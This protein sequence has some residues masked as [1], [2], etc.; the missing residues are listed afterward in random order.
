MWGLLTEGATAYIKSNTIG[1]HHQGLYNPGL[2]EAL[3]KARQAQGNDLPPTLKLILLVSSY[4]QEQYHGR[5]YAKAQNLR[6]SLRASYD[7]T[8][9]D[10][11]VP[12]MPTTPMKSHRHVPGR[13]TRDTISHGWNMLANTGPFDMTGHPGLSIPCSKS[14]GLPVGLMLVGRHFDDGT[15]LQTAHAFEQHVDWETI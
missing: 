7:H 9:R 8:L 11:D 3:G 6:R 10:V 15:L 5:M 14:D 2:A 1:H 4:M 13:G 12:V